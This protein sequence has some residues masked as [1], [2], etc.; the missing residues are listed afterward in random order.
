MSDCDG[1]YARRTGPQSGEEVTSVERVLEV[2]FTGD[3]TIDLLDAEPLIYKAKVTS[4]ITC[5]QFPSVLSLGAV[6]RSC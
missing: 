2:V 6:E 1:R 5:L 3:T 4:A